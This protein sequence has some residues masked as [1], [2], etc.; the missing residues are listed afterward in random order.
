[1]PHIRRCKDL[2]TEF[3]PPLKNNWLNGYEKGGQP[4]IALNASGLPMIKLHHAGTVRVLFVHIGALK[5]YVAKDLDID[6][7]KIMISALENFIRFADEAKL[8]QLKNAGVPM[9]SDLMLAKSVYIFP[10]GYMSIQ[11]PTDGAMVYGFR[12][13][14][15]L[16]STVVDRAFGVHLRLMAQSARNTENFDKFRQFLLPRL[17]A[18]ETSVVAAGSDHCV[19]AGDCAGVA[20]AAVHHAPLTPRELAAS[21]ESNR[22]YKHC[23]SL[24]GSVG[25]NFQ[26]SFGIRIPTRGV[27]H[28]SRLCETRPKPIG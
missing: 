8:M 15:C 1:M 4:A 20:A 10:N 9:F 12:R 28:F 6:E 14:I 27:K 26:K 7:E 25:H 5:E 17:A 23:W 11:I 24:W 19:Q 21:V 16:P 18:T 2:P 13:S 3:Q 22:C